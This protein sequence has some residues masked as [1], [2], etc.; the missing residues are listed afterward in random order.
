MSIGGGAI[1]AVDDKDIDR[2]FGALE[3]E[4]Q[5]L[6][7]RTEDSGVR[8]ICRRGK[9][10]RIIAELQTDSIDPLEGGSMDKGGD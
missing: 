2:G 3:F 10:C 1:D 9:P 4:A 6:L 7:D 5:L 8:G